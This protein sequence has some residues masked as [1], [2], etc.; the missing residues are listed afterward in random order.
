M[1]RGPP[2]DVKLQKNLPDISLRRTA[3]RAISPTR[4][5][6]RR[7][8]ANIAKLPELLHR[9]SA[10]IRCSRGVVAC[11]PTSMDIRLKPWGECPRALFVGKSP[12]SSPSSLPL[13]LSLP[14]QRSHRS[15]LRSGLEVST[16]GPGTIATMMMATIEV[17]ATEGRGV[18]SCDKPVSTRK[19]LGEQGMGNCRKYRDFADSKCPSGEFLNQVYQL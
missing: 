11:S 16:S 3:W 19:E 17:I 2:L 1:E 6:A 5:E 9:A 18:E 7:I 14:L 12:R 15:M 8:A 4:D 13:S 10:K